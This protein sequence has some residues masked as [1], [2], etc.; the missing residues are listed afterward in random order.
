MFSRCRAIGSKLMDTTGKQRNPPKIIIADD[1]T[2]VT[3]GL[4]KLLEADYEVMATVG[5]VAPWY[6]SLPL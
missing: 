6:A 1:H 3:E 2:L 4:K 5:T